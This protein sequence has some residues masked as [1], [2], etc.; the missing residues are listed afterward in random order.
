MYPGAGTFVLI[1]PAQTFYERINIVFND[2]EVSSRILSIID[3]AKESVVFVTPYIRLWEHVK[4]A[5]KLAT[6]RGVKVTFLVRADPEVVGGPDVKWL[7][8]AKID[9]RKVE[10]LHAKIYLNEDSIILS[11]MNLIESSSKNS[12]EIGTLIGNRDEKQAIRD[13][14]ELTLWKLAKPLDQREET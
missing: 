11:S 7:Q 12:L 10:R 8:D 5:L 6:K 1:R 2:E 9:V 4:D 3:D 14:I 13:Y